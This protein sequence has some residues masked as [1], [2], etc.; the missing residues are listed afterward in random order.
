[1]S[2]IMNQTPMEIIPSYEEFKKDIDSLEF[3]TKI[4]D[5]KSSSNEGTEDIIKELSGLSIS[6][7][8]IV[9]TIEDHDRVKHEM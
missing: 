1:M 8:I 3:K 4:K 2:E 7:S 6:K 9:V 5:N